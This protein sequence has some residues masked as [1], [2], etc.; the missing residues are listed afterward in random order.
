MIFESKLNICE[1]LSISVNVIK[2]TCLIRN[3]SLRNLEKTK[4]K[5]SNEFNR[6]FKQ[7]E[8]DVSIDGL[9]PNTDKLHIKLFCY[10]FRNE[11]EYKINRQTL[12]TNC[13]ANFETRT[14]ELR[15]VTINGNP[16]EE[17]DSSIQHE[18]NHIFQFSNGA[19]KNE[20]LYSCIVDV[21]NDENST[22]QDKLVA[23]LLYLSFKTEQDSFVNQYYAYLKQNNVDWDSVY[24]YFPDAIQNPYSKFLDT[25]DAIDQTILTDKYLLT[26]FDINKKQFLMRIDKTDKRMRNKMMKA[27]AKYRKDITHPTIDLKNTNRLNFMLESISNGIHCGDN[28]F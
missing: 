7:T 24:D 26:K 17:F 11:N 19:S 21:S 18:V 23:Y 6:F 16:N 20:D 28:E 8:F 14:I 1:E 27:A 9:I 5:S 10:C 3:E 13:I 2:V 22:Y 25:Y 15:L 4:L 12:N